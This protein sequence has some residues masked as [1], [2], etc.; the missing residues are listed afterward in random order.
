ME[1]VAFSIS[2]SEGT[3]IRIT[4]LLLCPVPQRGVRCTA[5]VTSVL[6]VGMVRELYSSS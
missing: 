5:L 2:S 6:C 1:G 3:T 4:V